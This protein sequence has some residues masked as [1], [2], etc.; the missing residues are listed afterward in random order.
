MLWILRGERRI[1]TVSSLIDGPY[2][3][4]NV[5]LSL[6]TLLSKEGV[7]KVIATQI[8]EKELEQLKQS[9]S[10]IKKAFDSIKEI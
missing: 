9:A 8:N 10:V 5:T 3:I 1:V 2:G 6:P 4:Q 7:E